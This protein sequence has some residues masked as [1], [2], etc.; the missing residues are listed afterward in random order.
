[1]KRKEPEDEVEVEE[2]S[3]GNLGGAAL[4]RSGES[5]YGRLQAMTAISNYLPLRADQTAVPTS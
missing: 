4:G 2:K 5:G 3:C 1:V